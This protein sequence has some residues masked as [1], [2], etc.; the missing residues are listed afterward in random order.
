MHIFGDGDPGTYDQNNGADGALRQHSVLD[1][2]RD[3]VAAEHRHVGVSLAA[4]G[5]IDQTY[6]SVPRYRRPAET[7]YR[8]HQEALQRLVHELV[9]RGLLDRLARRAEHAS[10]KTH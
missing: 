4:P 9:K 6:V 7:L 10:K 5:R 1:G 8:V 3:Q 2:I